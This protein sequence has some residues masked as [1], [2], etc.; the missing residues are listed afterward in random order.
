M[1][2]TQICSVNSD[3]YPIS[4]SDSSVVSDG[5]SEVTVFNGICNSNIGRVRNYSLNKPV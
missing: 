1:T 2:E 3:Q 4:N 5:M